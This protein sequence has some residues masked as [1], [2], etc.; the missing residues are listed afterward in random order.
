[1]VEKPSSSTEVNLFKLGPKL[2][3][4]AESNS[5]ETPRSLESEGLPSDITCLP[6]SD[7]VGMGRT[8]SRW[9]SCVVTT[10]AN[11]CRFSGSGSSK[12]SLFLFNL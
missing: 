5:K 6:L 11:S 4:K 10:S 12:V 8:F 2:S 7:C 3:S 1:M 9:S